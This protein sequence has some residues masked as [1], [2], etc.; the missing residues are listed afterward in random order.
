ML[1]VSFTNNTSATQV[2]G[3]EIPDYSVIYI[4]YELMIIS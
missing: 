2:I 4:Y 1:H 3:F